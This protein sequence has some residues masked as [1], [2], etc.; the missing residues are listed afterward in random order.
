MSK[1]QYGVKVS[2]NGNEHCRFVVDAES[3]IDALTQSL[4]LW[5]QRVIDIKHPHVDNV[6]LQVTDIK[7]IKRVEKHIK[8]RIKRKS[9]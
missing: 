7:V 8:K 6:N 5:E 2:S 4:L 3:N 1:S 9:V